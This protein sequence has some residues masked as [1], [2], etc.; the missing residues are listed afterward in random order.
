MPKLP[1]P[2]LQE[3]PTPQ[4]PGGVASYRPA[5]GQET[6]IGDEAARTGLRV[7]HGGEE[8]FRA[9]KHEEDRINTMRA[10]EA[11]TTLRNRQ[12][13]LTLG[14]QDGFAN[15]KGGAAVN[16]PVLKEWGDKFDGAVKEIEAGLSNDQQRERFRLRAGVSRTQFDHDI[17]QHR[18][19]E[20]KVWQK[21]VFD[22]TVT[23]ELRNVVANWNQPN[24]VAV[25]IERV[26][27]A[28]RDRAEQLAWPAEYTEAVRLEK[29]GQIHSSIVKQALA[30][31]DYLFA[32]QWADENKGDLDSATQAAVTK[33]VEDG[34]Q[35]QVFADYQRDFLGSRDNSKMLNELGKKVTA[36][37]ALDDTRK[38]VLL[39]RIE[40]RM[41][42]LAQKADADYQRQMRTIE[43]GINELNSNTLAGFPPNEGQFTQFLSAAKGTEMEL[44]VVAAVNLAKATTSFANKPPAQQEAILAQAEAGIR[45][46]P[47]KFDRNVISAWRTIYNNQ[48][49]QVKENPIAFAVRQGVLEPK[50]LDLSNPTQAGDALVQRFAAARG[51]AGTYGVQMKP[52]TTEEAK[53]VSVTLQGMGPAQRRDYFAGLAQAAGGD[54]EG[55]SAIM[56]QIAPDAPVV[57]IAGQYAGRGRTQAADLL[58]GGLAILQPNRKDDGQPDKGKLWPMPPEGDMRR[59]FSDFEKDA[60]AGRPK[61]QS[62][63]RQAATAIYAKL[64]A[65]AGDASGI[66]DSGRMEQAMKL[67]TGGV[68][69]W[70]GKAIVLPYGYERGQFKTELAKRLDAI[71]DAGQLADGVTKATL[72]DLPLEPVGDG[73]YAFKAGDG[74]MVGKDRRPIIVDF[75]QSVPFQTSGH[76]MGDPG[77]P[78][79]YTRALREVSFGSVIR[80]VGDEFKGAPAATGIGGVNSAPVANPSPGGRVNPS[81]GIRG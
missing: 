56:A 4:S 30:E 48:R 47:T 61:M 52:L 25:S 71:A 58:L 36:D 20:Y 79:A 14:E 46:D 37:S 70:N 62:D 33:A 43:R 32:K 80:S 9:A 39:A 19:R 51:I 11:F 3:R 77:K 16:R 65:D 12:L 29:M 38:N 27:A 72:Y 5:T 44:R 1:D 57:A 49:E 53:L 34:V 10:E 66:L 40:G 81:G 31:G 8:L 18:D 69:K 23:T 76:G 64:S 59:A 63:M 67:A 60:F 42:V 13:D 55:Y 28:I 78:D 26:N 7:F 17:L 21:E 74:V 35:K 73:R 2:G 41:G 22:G 54:M 68:E 6:A 24:N 50:P 45:Q 75:N 15:L